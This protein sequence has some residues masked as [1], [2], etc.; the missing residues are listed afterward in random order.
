MTFSNGDSPRYRAANCFINW[1]GNS[2]LSCNFFFLSIYLGKSVL[3]NFDD[4]ELEQG[5]NSSSE[6]NIVREPLLEGEHHAENYS[7]L[8]AVLPWV[9]TNWVHFVIW[10]IEFKHLVLKLNI[11]LVSIWNVTVRCAVSGIAS[12]LFD[13]LNALCL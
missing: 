3:C 9:S 1:Q 13:E 2:I 10:V 5:E 7:V 6:I 8:S 11:V 4:C 12:H